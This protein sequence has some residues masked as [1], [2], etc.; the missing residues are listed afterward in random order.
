M[1]NRPADRVLTACALLSMAVGGC[2]AT[3]TPP[4][5]DCAGAGHAIEELVCADAGLAAKDRRLAD[6][7][8]RSL[9][10]LASTADAADAIRDLKAYQRGWIGGRNDCWKAADQRQCVAQ[11]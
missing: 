5:F 1:C 11:S 7:Y 3:D 9:D 6:V 10:K 2:A 4:A 8:D